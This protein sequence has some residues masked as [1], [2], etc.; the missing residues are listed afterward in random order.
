M[1][2]TAQTAITVALLIAT[3][4]IGTIIIARAADPLSE[5]R[6]EVC[7]SDNPADCKRPA[8]VTPRWRPWQQIWQCNDIRLTVT[9]WQQGLIDYDLG[10]SI[11]GGSR[12]T[13]DLRRDPWGAYIFNGRPCARLQ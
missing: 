11:W 12:F 10:G 4:L 1:K 5:D 2:R 8:A 3:F 13:V 9:S 7:D 6:G